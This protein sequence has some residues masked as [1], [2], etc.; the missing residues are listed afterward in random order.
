MCY[1]EGAP[2]ATGSR[3]IPAALGAQAGLA[4]VRSIAKDALG[5]QPGWEQG[6]W[7]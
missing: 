1:E 2:W 6:P 5:R 3:E 4:T 7:I